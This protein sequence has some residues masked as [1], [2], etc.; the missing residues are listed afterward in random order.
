M[1]GQNWS[2]LVRQHQ[3]PNARFSGK[4]RPRIKGKDYKS[5]G[6]MIFPG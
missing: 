5:F 3:P 6:R 1:L 2:M 4:G